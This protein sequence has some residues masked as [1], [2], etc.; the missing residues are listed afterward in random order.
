MKKAVKRLSSFL[1]VMFMAGPI[2]GSVIAEAASPGDVNVPVIEEMDPRF[3][4]IIAA[5]S[6]I[7]FKDG[8]GIAGSTLDGK[9][10]LTTKIT[11]HTYLQQYKNGEWT[12]LGGSS[13]TTNGYYAYNT[14][15]KAIPKGYKYRTKSIFYVYSGTDKEK[16]TNYSKVATYN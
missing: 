16:H 1:L 5:T 3:A 4:Y 12:T 9:K 10:S 14:Y 13:K 11:I 6:T 15:S 8:Q 2:S 7:G